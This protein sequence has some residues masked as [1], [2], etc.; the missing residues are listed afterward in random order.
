[1]AIR[2][3]ASAR[4]A[5]PTIPCAGASA[6]ETPSTTKTGSRDVSGEDRLPFVS[7]AELVRRVQ[8]VH[9]LAGKIGLPTFDELTRAEEELADELRRYL[10]A[11]TR[12]EWHDWETAAVLAD[13]GAAF[14]ELGRYVDAVDCYRRAWSEGQ[15]SDVPMHVLEQLGN[16][17]IRLAQNLR[18]REPVEEGIESALGSRPPPVEDL[19]T[20]AEA[21]LSLALQVGITCGRLALLG[22]YHKK[23]ATLTEREKRGPHLEASCAHYRQAHEQRLADTS[24]DDGK[25]RVATVS[26]YYTQAW[27]Q[28]SVLARQP[29]DDALAAVL[30]NAIDIA[31]RRAEG[32]ARRRGPG[33]RCGASGVGERGRE[34]RRL[35]G[36][37]STRANNMLTRGV[38]DGAVD[39]DSLADEYR[40]AFG[41]RASRRN[42]DSTVDHLR[43]LAVLMES[44]ALGRLADELM[45]TVGASE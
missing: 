4:P 5:A 32:R 40:S 33:R 12:P 39:V 15:S 27:L 16:L 23:M 25:L 3:S 45:S 10:R 17:E 30:L 9:A 35:L 24:I 11:L 18:R 29:I 43:D 41:T 42:R 36:A 26:P 2:V 6:S 38:L 13:F 19:V 1:M 44:E 31:P 14:G 8:T 28:M 22:S 20:T 7:E 37:G 34:A 21:R